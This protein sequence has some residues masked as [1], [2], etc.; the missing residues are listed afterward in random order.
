MVS[1]SKQEKLPKG[2]EAPAPTTIISFSFFKHIMVLLVIV[3][4]LKYI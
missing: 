2:I 1:M 4:C 3:V